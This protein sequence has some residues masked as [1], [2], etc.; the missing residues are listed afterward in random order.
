MWTNLLDPGPDPKPKPKPN[1]EEVDE[2]E[3]EVDEAPSSSEEEEPS[4]L[5]VIKPLVAESPRIE[6][7]WVVLGSLSMSA[8][9]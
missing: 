1:T 6:R 5:A 3:E 9:E 8:S 2:G 7:L 4:S